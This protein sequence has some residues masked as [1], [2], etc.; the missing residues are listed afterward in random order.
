[1]HIVDGYTREEVAELMGISLNAVEQHI[2][3]QVTK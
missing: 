2:S 3:E 1:M